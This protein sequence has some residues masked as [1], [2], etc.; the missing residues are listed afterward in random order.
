MLKSGGS[1]NSRHLNRMLL[2]LAAVFALA[3][4]LSAQPPAE[5]H[6]LHKYQFGAAP[7]SSREYFDYMFFD[8]ESS[9][10]Y[11]S[12]GTE[13]LVVNAD[14]GKEVGKIS[15]LKLSH[16]I[17]VAHDFG[18]GF[19]SDGEQGKAIIFDLKTLKVVGEANAAPDADCIIYDPAS[20]H[21]FTFN[22]DS[23]NATAIDPATGNPV[24]TIDLGGGPEFA[25]ADGQGMIYNNLED[26]SEV[27]AIDS[28]NLQ[29]KSRWPIAPAGAPAPIAMDREHRRLFVAGREPAILVVMNA[30]DGKVVQSFPISNGADADVFDPRSGLVFVSTREGWVHIF[31]EDSPDHFS[32]AGKV[33]TELGAK[34]MAYDPKSDRIFVDTANFE[35]PPQPTKEH[36][37]PR[38]RAVPGTFQLLEYGR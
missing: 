16:G 28:R 2:S 6:L 25:V 34:T 19:V 12:H 37:H 31:H 30:D 29:V 22:G 38:P 7:G 20:K 14:T 10:L 24:G 26:K 9:R 13:V 1:L 36:P 23:K 8:P 17:A 35:K 15:G 11:L 4:T 32:E 5:Y 33:K 3:S 21:I 18:R 27:L